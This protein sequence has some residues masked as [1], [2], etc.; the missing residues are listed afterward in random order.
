MTDTTNLLHYQ[1]P[2]DLLRDR[3]IAIT[4]AG[5][6]LGRAAAMTFARHGATVVLLG[7]TLAKLEVVYD[8][9]EA[10]GHPQ[11][12]IFPINLEGAAPQDYEQL[13]IAL[14]NEFGRLDGLLHNAAELGGR[15]PLDTYSL[16]DWNKAMQVNVT[17]PFLLTRALLPLLRQ[18]ADGRIVFTGSNVGRKGRA[19][20]GAYAVSKGAMET[21]MQVLADELEA[22]PIRVNSIHP[23]PLRTRLRA[24]AYPAEDPVS[25]PLPESVMNAYLFLFGPDGRDCHGQQ[26][27]AQAKEDG[28]KPQIEVGE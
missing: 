1:A 19:Y 25:V 23:G 24:S 22:T 8:E 14:E 13:R 2:P 9:I 3:V 27:N 7:R 4:G 28:E 21:L 6:G 20:W 12:A 26:L 16:G 18:S 5:D 15:T 11:P 10:G 17:A